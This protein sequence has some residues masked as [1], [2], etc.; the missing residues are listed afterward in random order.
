MFVVIGAI[1]VLS[2]LVISYNYLVRGKF[3]ESREI[4]K[5]VR[6]TKCSQSVCKYIFAYL[7]RDLYDSNKETNSSGQVLRKIFYECNDQYKLKERFEKEWLN[8]IDYK[9]ICKSIL[10][11]T[12]GNDGIDCE[13]EVGFSN[14]NSLDSLRNS[15]GISSSVFFFDG[16]KV[17][18]LTI[19]VNVKIGRSNGIWQETRPFKVVFPFKSY[20]NLAFLTLIVTVFDAI[21]FPFINNSYIPLS[22]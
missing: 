3:N 18:R 7:F 19:R 17:G 16:E 14:I 4:L 20:D 15:K 13:V 2:L 11:D 6:A 1:L 10:E 12:I 9:G 8:N 21:F 5:H 22:F